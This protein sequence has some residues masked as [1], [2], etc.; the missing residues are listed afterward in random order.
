M[1]LEVVKVLDGIKN[2]WIG[3]SPCCGKSTISEM[4]V[5]EFG[6]ALY[7][8]DDH[9]DRYIEIG[10]NNGVDIMKKYKSRSIDEIWLRDINELV[11]DEFEFYRQAL[12]T[13]VT[14]LEKNYKG[15]K[16]LVEGAAILPEFIKNKGIDYNNYVCIIPT[17]KF[18]V[19]QYSKREWVEHY[20]S[21]CSEP[22]KAFGNWMERDAKYAEI[23]SQNAK[24]F[25]MNVI[26]VDGSKSIEENYIIVKQLFKLL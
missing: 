13:I 2:Y 5:K 12:I 11:E 26:V 1:P 21:D 18:Q 17:K 8:C 16:V 24:N 3:G 7:K 9:L 6:F 22:A 4:L 15:K 25:G 14:D 19:D 10:F 20:L 23:V